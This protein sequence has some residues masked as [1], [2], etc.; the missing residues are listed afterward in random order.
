MIRTILLDLD[1]T[2]LDFEQCA[3]TAMRQGF[4][5]FGIPYEAEM[6]ST[7]MET[8][9]ALWREVE[10]GRMTREELHRVRWGQIFEK[11]GI[12]QDGEQFEPCFYTNL[13]ESHEIV[14]GAYELLEYLSPRYAL[15]IATNAPYEQ[16]RRRLEKAGMLQ[17]FDHVFTS[18][19]IGYTKPSREFFEHCFQALGGYTKEEIL[20]IGDSLTADIQGGTE[21]GIKTCWYNH[22]QE[23]RDP[24][25][26]PDYTVDRLREILKLL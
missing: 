3:E 11:L 25:F 20:M 19:R 12:Q 14:E 10:Q 9:N 2:L 18:E 1:N 16:Q 7:F 15:S 8:N 17:Y 26:H 22:N 23:P 5:R 24:A 13:S 21:F 6:F 4:F